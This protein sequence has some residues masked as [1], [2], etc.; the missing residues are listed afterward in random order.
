M[1]T[2]AAQWS[3]ESVES[4]PVVP[5]AAPDASDPVEVALAEALK[6]ATAAGQWST[7]AQLARELEARRQA[8]AGTVDLAAARKRR[9]RR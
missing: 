7:V 9:G 2:D 6:G 3:P 5:D 4:A 8:K 1:G